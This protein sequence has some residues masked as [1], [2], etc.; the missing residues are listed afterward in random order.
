MT[1]KRTFTSDSLRADT[2]NFNTK[3]LFNKK[4]ERNCEIFEDSAGISNPNSFSNS[5][6]RLQR[7]LSPNFSKTKPRPRETS[8]TQTSHTAS[9]I[10]QT[11]FS[12]L[13]SRNKESSSKN[14]AKISS[15]SVGEI[16]WL[17]S[18]EA[19][20][21]ENGTNFGVAQFY[22]QN[23]LTLNNVPRIKNNQKLHTFS[24]L[25]SEDTFQLKYGVPSNEDK[26][27]N[28]NN[29]FHNPEQLLQLTNKSNQLTFYNTKNVKKDTRLMEKKDFQRRPARHMDSNQ[30][31]SLKLRTKHFHQPNKPFSALFSQEAGNQ[32]FTK[33]LSQNFN[34]R[35]AQLNS[36]HIG[37]EKLSYLQSKETKAKKQQILS[38]SFSIDQLLKPR[39]F[40]EMQL[41][42]KKCS[43]TFL[44]DSN[45]H[46]EILKSPSSPLAKQNNILHSDNWFHRFSES[47]IL[48]FSKENIQTP[49]NP[50][51]YINNKISNE[52]PEQNPDKTKTVIDKLPETASKKRFKEIRIK[53]AAAFRNL[54]RLNINI[55]EVTKKLF[56]D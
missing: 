11:R 10:N 12:N 55:K 45:K 31:A 28:S 47:E 50:L 2:F 7:I 51:L 56:F 21:V 17:S 42:L 48:Q 44:I 54:A 40:R 6:V 5:K 24:G 29:K 13:N 52:N 33:T 4:D 36:S 3:L 23:I 18:Q 19:L 39:I 53:L 30:I 1:G 32:K 9:F 20:K 38:E 16:K 49:P 15:K 25:K 37:E 46:N 26:S 34:E 22:L 41:T 8:P 35:K 27:S 14:I 43:K